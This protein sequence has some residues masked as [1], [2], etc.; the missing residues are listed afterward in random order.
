MW[1][2]TL[3]L[4]LIAMIKETTK[5]MLLI[6]LALVSAAIGSTTTNHFKDGKYISLNVKKALG[7]IYMFSLIK[8]ICIFEVKMAQQVFINPRLG[9]N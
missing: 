2:T 9:M 7:G 5:G 6:I 1:T 8:S 3:L 4:L